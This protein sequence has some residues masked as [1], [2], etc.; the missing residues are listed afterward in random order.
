MAIPIID[1]A[2]ASVAPDAVAQNVLQACTEWGE[3][4][5]L[6]PPDDERAD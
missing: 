3:D 6:R 4:K 1:F 5:R 2:Q